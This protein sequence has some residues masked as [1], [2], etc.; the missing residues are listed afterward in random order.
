MKNY[1]EGPPRL[2]VD[3]GTGFYVLGNAVWGSSSAW[4]ER[5]GLEVT[6]AALR[7]RL[8]RAACRY[9][10]VRSELGRLTKFYVEEDVQRARTDLPRFR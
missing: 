5:L 2:I 6:A 10:W 1:D 7:K 4:V 9:M 8:A 3:D